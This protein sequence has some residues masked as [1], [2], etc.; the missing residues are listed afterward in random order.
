M[1]LRIQK[2]LSQSLNDKLDYRDVALV[3][4]NFIEQVSFMIFIR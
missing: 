3:S 1:S 2:G 4:R